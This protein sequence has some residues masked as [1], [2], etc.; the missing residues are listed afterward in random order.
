MCA[1]C[2]PGNLLAVH[3]I[4]LCTPFL[5]YDGM[6]APR[7]TYVLSLIASES[8]STIT[9]IGEGFQVSTSKIHVVANPLA[10]ASQPTSGDAS[11]SAGASQ[12]SYSVLGFCTLDHLSAFRLDPPRG[13]PTRC[14]LCVI[15]R[16]EQDIFHILKLECLEPEQ[17]TT[18]I[19]CIRKLRTLCK[20][21]RPSSTEKRSHDVR[22]CADAMPK[23]LKKART[24]QTVPTD[25]SM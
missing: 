24:L 18:A 10:C 3:L 1:V 15:S 20:G 16:R 13:K 6:Q 11:S 22:V 23:Q 8:K 17:V 19:D 12:L 4:L 21:I 5:L 25:K 2:E 14:A 9:N 7:S